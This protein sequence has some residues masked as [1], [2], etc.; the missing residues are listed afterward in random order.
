MQYLMDSDDIWVFES[1]QGLCL[2]G[3]TL[4][5]NFVVFGKLLFARRDLQIGIALS[6]FSW[7][8]LFNRHLNIQVHVGCQVSHGKAAAT[9]YIVDLI[10]A[11]FIAALKCVLVT[12]HVGLDLSKK[13]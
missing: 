1:R 3:E 10:A 4:Q 5:A 13:Q 9:E 12:A 7:Q 6:N 2:T 8:V 11:D